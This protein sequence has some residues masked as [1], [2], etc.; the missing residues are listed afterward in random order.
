[1]YRRNYKVHA[2]LGRDIQLLRRV[3][4]IL[5]TCAGT[6]FIRMSE[7]LEGVD[8]HLRYGPSLRYNIPIVKIYP[9][10]VL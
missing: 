9:H 1:M 6:N 8:D 3:I 4:E 2:D 10:L 5:D 7:L